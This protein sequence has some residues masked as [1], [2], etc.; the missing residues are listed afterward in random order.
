M[1]VGDGGGAAGVDGQQHS[2]EQHAGVQS[3]SAAAVGADG[4]QEL[5]GGGFGDVAGPAV[6]VGGDTHG[7]GPYGAG[8]SWVL[9]WWCRLRTVLGG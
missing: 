1:D 5:F 8:T 7:R 3:G 6:V 4:G 2:G 9:W